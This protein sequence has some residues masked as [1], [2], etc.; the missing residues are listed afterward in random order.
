MFPKTFLVPKSDEDSQYVR[1]RNN[2]IVLTNIE[3]N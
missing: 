3:Q 2:V 1:R